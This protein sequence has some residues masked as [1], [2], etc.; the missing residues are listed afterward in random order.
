M[1][2]AGQRRR[3]VLPRT[4]RRGGA[5]PGRGRPRRRDHRRG[6]PRAR[7]SDARLRRRYRTPHRRAH[8]SPRPARRHRH[9]QRTRPGRGT[10]APRDPHRGP[11]GPRRKARADCRPMRPTSGGLGCAAVLR[12]TEP[13]HPNRHE[14]AAAPPDQ[15][16][17]GQ[18]SPALTSAN[19]GATRRAA[20]RLATTPDPAVGESPGCTVGIV[21]ALRDRG[22]RV[23]ESDS[24]SCA[25]RAAG[26]PAAPTPTVSRP[27]PGS[28]TSS[29]CGRPGM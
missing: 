23:T 27:R 19:A 18:A 15:F 20:P 16:G 3:R 11:P 25:D 8:A 12:P 7:P 17:L 29:R 13:E 24:S 22:W 14:R 21:R 26:S 9:R 4:A 6:S 10:L 28:R 5:G 2:P 1:A